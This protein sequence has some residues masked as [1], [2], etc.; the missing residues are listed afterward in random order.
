MECSVNDPV[1]ELFDHK[2][3]IQIRLPFLQLLDQLVWNCFAI[4]VFPDFLQ[5]FLFIGEVLKEL[6]GNLDEI[7]KHLRSLERLESRV[8]HHCMETM[9]KFVERRGDIVKRNQV[10]S[11]DVFRRRRIVS[12][13]REGLWA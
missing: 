13:H 1:A 6:A 5:H 12:D 4:F 7:P 8:R 2:G 9:S 11:S 10:S 3:R